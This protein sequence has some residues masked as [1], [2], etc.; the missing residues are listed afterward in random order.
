V[1]AP[2]ANG[3]LKAEALEEGNEYCTKQGREFVL[4]RTTETEPPYLLGNYPRAE[5]EFRCSP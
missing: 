3:E 5:I 1:W 4:I 2:W